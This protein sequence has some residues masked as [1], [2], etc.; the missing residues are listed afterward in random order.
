M[1]E[2]RLST[3]L[4]DGIKAFLKDLDNH[5]YR[6]H[7]LMIA[8]GDDVIYR[9]IAEPYTF[10]TPHRLFSSAKSILV[11]GIMKAMQDG[12]L[13]T[14]DY[15]SD[16]FPEYEVTDPRL[17]KMIVE[18]LLTMCTGQEEDP[19]VLLFQDFD[20]DLFEAF[21]KTPA[22][23]MPGEKFRYNNTVPHLVYGVTERAV[24]EPFEVYMNRHF[25]DPLHA[26]LL[27]PINT[28]GQYNPVVT[29]TSADSF[30]KYAQ[31]FLLEGTYRGK[32]YIKPE[33]IREATRMH[34]ATGME[35]NY[36]GY[37]WQIWMNKFG[38][39]RMDGGWGQYAFILPQE[40]IAVTVMSDMTKCEYLVEAFEHILFPAIK[41]M[42]ADRNETEQIP[43]ISS[44]A[45]VGKAIPDT[46]LFDEVFEGEGIS[47]KLQLKCCEEGQQKIELIQNG[48]SYQIG[49][50]YFV[51]NEGYRS[52]DFSID[53]SVYGT[54]NN[55]VLLAGAFTESD[56][57]I[58]RGKCFGEMG[59]TYC[60]MKFHSDSVE[61][62]YTPLSIHGIS[63]RSI[64][65]MKE[66][67]LWRNRKN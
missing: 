7:S 55:E 20:T 8:S 57:L 22:V 11:L 67:I 34:T 36:A 9:S 2:M 3:R 46:E 43:Q 35:G 10:D 47:I 63:G 40:N 23:E 1:K 64:E 17:K 60:Q 44:L 21:F 62:R 4:C 30:M 37:G 42:A 27:A 54:K 53:H 14:T 32:E 51:Q 29:C 50:G 49:L 5:D 45:P 24:N 48:K 15:V 28:K 18:D 59:E 31:L 52:R 25:C 66:V 19:F 12:Y 41:E 65:E 56:V 39:Y 26:P 33:L 58:I 13:K 16:F 38:G 61:V 6:I